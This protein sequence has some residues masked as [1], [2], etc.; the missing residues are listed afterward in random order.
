MT[1]LRGR[2][3]SLDKTMG[4][5]S[6]GAEMILDS[7]EMGLDSRETGQDFI[8]MVQDSIIM[9]RDSKVKVMV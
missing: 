6:L 1:V 8:T 3:P 9:N 4:T 5:R 7:R 2:V